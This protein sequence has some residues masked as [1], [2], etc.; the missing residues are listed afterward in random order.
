MARIMKNN[1][2]FKYFL[3]ARYVTDV[4]FQLNNRAGGNIQENRKYFSGQ[5]HLYGLQTE[6]SVLPNGFGIGYSNYYSGTVSDIAIFCDNLKWNRSSTKKITDGDVDVVDNG[7]MHT[8]FPDSC[9]WAFIANK[10]Y[11]GLHE[12]IR[13]IIPRKAAEWI[14]YYFG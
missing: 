11:S 9:S 4:D 12:V 1:F 8:K 2:E 6:F 10:S 14:S 5:H 13:I 7:E 3:E